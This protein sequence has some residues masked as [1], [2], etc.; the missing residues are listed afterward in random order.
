MK[1]LGQKV[2]S[3]PNLTEPA[4]KKQKLNSN[5]VSLESSN[6]FT[7]KRIQMDGNCLYRAILYC[8]EQNDESHYQ[9]RE[10]LYTFVKEKKNL[11]ILSLSKLKG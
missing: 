9:L 4:P 8:L 2:T 11:V 1:N 10:E 3:S 6:R 5:H 7:R